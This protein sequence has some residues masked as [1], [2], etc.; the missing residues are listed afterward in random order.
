M[1]SV[2]EGSCKAF[3]Y[4]KIIGGGRLNEYAR[5][6]K[7]F[8]KHRVKRKGAFYRYTLSQKNSNRETC[9]FVRK[10]S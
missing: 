1:L 2:V 7:K 3:F 4:N 8:Y 5:L 9:L 6:I 10:L